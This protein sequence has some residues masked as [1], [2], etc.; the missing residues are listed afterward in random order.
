MPTQS[1][2]TVTLRQAIRS[3]RSCCHRVKFA[4][5]VKSTCLTPH[6]ILKKTCQLSLLWPLLRGESEIRDIAMGL[7]CRMTKN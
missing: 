7:G 4:L 1:T 3:I 5:V 6:I 2:A